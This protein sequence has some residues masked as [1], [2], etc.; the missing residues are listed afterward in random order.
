MLK[1]L[2]K[3]LPLSAKTENIHTELPSSTLSWFQIQTSWQDKHFLS[4][5]A[6]GYGILSQQWKPELRQ[7]LVPGVGYFLWQTWL[8]ILWIIVKG[9]WNFE[10]EKPLS[11]F[12]ELGGVFCKNIEDIVESS[13]EH[14]SLDCDFHRELLRVL[15]DFIK[16][17]IC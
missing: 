10:L 6:T 1:T 14:E 3:G 8:Y 4:C 17:L 12:S 9:L 11:E 13:A 16:Q 2:G 5:V 15:K 7:K